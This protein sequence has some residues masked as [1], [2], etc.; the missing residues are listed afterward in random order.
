MSPTCT[1]FHGTGGRTIYVRT[2]LP[3]GGYFF[4]QQSILDDRSRPCSKF[5]RIRGSGSHDNYYVWVPPRYVVRTAFRA[6]EPV[7]QKKSSNHVVYIYFHHKSRSSTT[8]KYAYDTGK[9]E[10]VIKYGSRYRQLGRGKFSIKNE[11]D[12]PNQATKTHYKYCPRRPRLLYHPP[13]LAPCPSPRK[14]E[15][16]KKSHS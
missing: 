1:P 9:R 3:S 16:E 7:Q 10:C 11:T 13:P 6:C 12:K 2:Q 14:K 8:T 15:K 5:R 4:L